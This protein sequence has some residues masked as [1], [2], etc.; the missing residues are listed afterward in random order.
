MRHKKLNKRF[1]RNKSQR[2]QLLRS[3]V[4]SLFVSYS[5]QTTAE[6][7]KEAKKIAD[8]II[9]YAKSGT[10]NDIREIERILQDRALI[11]KIMKVIAPISKDRKGGHTRIIRSGFRRGDGAAL[12]I[13]QLTDM[14]VKEEKQ[15]KIK[16]T[17]PKASKEQVSEDVESDKALPEKQPEQMHRKEQPPKKENISSKQ[18]PQAK[19]KKEEP[20]KARDRDKKSMPE[21]PSRGKK[22]V[23]G[24]FKKFFRNKNQ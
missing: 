24:R 6:K 23:L 5:I 3:L 22:D 17:K 19:V 2:K 14:P 12:A 20:S 10:L 1:G 4:R 21:K 16:K 15:R 11:S 18:P 8:N 9:T 13:L 7:A